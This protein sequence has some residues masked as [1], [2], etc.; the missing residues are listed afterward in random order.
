M[1][2]RREK[3][4]KRID[5]TR[6]WSEGRFDDDHAGKE[7]WSREAKT[8]KAKV[9]KTAEQVFD[10]S[11]RRLAQVTEV[12][13]RSCVIR[14]V[15]EINSSVATNVP[16]ISQ[17]TLCR[18]SPVLLTE[19]ARIPAVGDIIETAPET[20][21]LEL[22]AL[23]IL[24]RTSALTRP[25]PDDRIHRKL[26]LAANI[27]QIVVI[28]SVQNPEF[29]YGFADRFLLAAGLSDL[30]VILVLNKMD[31]CQS[32][33]PPAQEF[34]ELATLLPVSVTN[35]TGM[36]HLKSILHNKTSVFTGQSG[37]GKSTIINHLIP[38]L[39]LRTG[40]VRNKDGKGRHTT[41][42]SSLFDLPFGGTVIDTP[43]IRGLGLQE[44]PASYLALEFPGFGPYAL[45][46]RFN[47]CTHRHEPNCA[48]QQAVQDGA[49]SEQR[50]RSYLRILQSL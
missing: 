13:R 7:R 32:I 2:S 50:F 43:G 30:P 35:N 9:Q 4:A 17:H 31:L 47:N 39:T 45:K 23:Q 38:G 21:S 8:P 42:S 16:S 33:P 27:D 10:T 46:C 18:Y 36:E 5:V 48:V 26:V 49:L 6:S 3:R 25:G 29:N 44:L 24:P 41:T 12:H 15:P 1:N 11:Q 34:S 14:P 22:Y 20:N 40:E 37:V 19:Y 28:T